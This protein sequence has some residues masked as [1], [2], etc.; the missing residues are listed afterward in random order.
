MGRGSTRLLLELVLVGVVLEVVL[1]VALVEY[2]L[3][4]T[5]VDRFS[6]SHSRAS[7]MGKLTS[8]SGGPP[9]ISLQDHPCQLHII[10]LIY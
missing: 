6:A 9:V 10:I 1:Q 2:Y 3:G 4:G 5:S 8:T 7:G